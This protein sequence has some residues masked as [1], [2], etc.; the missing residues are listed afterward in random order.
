MDKNNGQ[1]DTPHNSDRKA[2]ILV[3]I[4]PAYALVSL[5][6]VGLHYE[7]NRMFSFA[8]VEHKRIRRHVVSVGAMQNNQ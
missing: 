1:S 2:L 6:V 3:F 8:P 4:D 7:A 5:Q